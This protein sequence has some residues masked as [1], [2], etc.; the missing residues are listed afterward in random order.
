VKHNTVAGYHEAYK[1]AGVTRTFLPIVNESH[2]LFTISG[3]LALAVEKVDTPWKEQV[4]YA[5]TWEPLQ[6]DSYSETNR[7]ST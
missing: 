3:D 4:V 7:S 5:H 1:K 2:R 6:T